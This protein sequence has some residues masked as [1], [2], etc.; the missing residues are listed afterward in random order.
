[1]SLFLVA[2]SLGAFSLASAQPPLPPPGVT[3]ACNTTLTDMHRSM[4][5]SW[6][7][8]KAYNRQ[9]LKRCIPNSGRLTP[10]PNK[11]CRAQ[12]VPPQQPWVIDYIDKC[13]QEQGKPSFKDIDL[14][15]AGPETCGLFHKG[16]CIMSTSILSCMPVTCTPADIVLL[17]N[18]ES[19]QFCETMK[20]YN[21]SSCAIQF[22]EPKKEQAEDNNSTNYTCGNS[23]QEV[24]FVT[25]IDKSYYEAKIDFCTTGTHPHCSSCTVDEPEPNDPGPVISPSSSMGCR[26]PSTG[27]PSR[28][29]VNLRI[30]ADVGFVLFA[31]KS[32]GLNRTL[33]RGLYPDA[34]GKFP[35][36]YA[37]P[38]FEPPQ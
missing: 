7:S 9:C 4:M 15:W 1:M 33:T 8:Y 6:L 16:Q 21:L 31:A 30:G 24:G 37:L 28:C 32:S 22:V 35:R 36:D 29:T 11:I 34:Q 26:V 23:T 10:P 38:H 18:V 25:V 14:V 27:L 2:V 13:N 20:P 12:C 19:N 5:Q 3:S 17:A